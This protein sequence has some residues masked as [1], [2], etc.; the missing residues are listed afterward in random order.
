MITDSSDPLAPHVDIDAALVARLVTSQFPQ[1][2]NLPVTPVEADGWDNRT[3]RLGS[4]M[5]VRLPSAECYTA[6]VDKEH[7]WLPRL[8]PRL[9]LSIPVPLAM[10]AP[11]EGYPWNWSVYRWLEGSTASTERIDDINEFSTTLGHFLASLQRM[12]PTDGP[13]P[14][15]HNFY[16]GGPLET[17][18]DETRSAIAALEGRIAVETVTAVWDTAMA[19]TWNGSPVWFHGDVSA[20]NLLVTD[21]R[22]SAV[23][24]FG[25]SGVGDPACDL[26]VAW[27]LLSGESREALRAALTVDAAMWARGRGWALWK[28]VITLAGHID[29][30]GIDEEGARHVIDQLRA[31]QEGS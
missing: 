9:P 27:T 28:A 20:G 29:T 5:L 12:D 2:A 16:R 19:A 26:T 10:G 6:Q 8:A 1:W 4:D 22:L 21:G 24:D 31:D 3:F 30:N 25:C 15:Q 23:I 7:R 11:A 18:D 14:G 13:P 17:Y